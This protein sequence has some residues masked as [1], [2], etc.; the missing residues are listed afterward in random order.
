M[1]LRSRQR[2]LAGV[3]RDVYD[4][5]SN[6][7][8]SP[9]LE[10]HLRA[11]IDDVD[12]FNLMWKST[13]GYA[14]LVLAGYEVILLYQLL[15]GNSSHTSRLSLCLG[16]KLVALASIFSTREY[17]RMGRSSSLGQ[18]LFFSGSYVLIWVC[19]SALLHLSFSALEASPLC[20]FYFLASFIVLRLIGDNT[21]AEVARAQQLEKLQRLVG[22][23]AA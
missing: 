23:V 8:Q 12:A 1:G 10:E 19:C 5:E 22:G 16:L 3:T 6:S 15:T 20:L 2:R 18:S 14:G 21:K 11:S 13:M 17:V 4:P 7:I 9:S